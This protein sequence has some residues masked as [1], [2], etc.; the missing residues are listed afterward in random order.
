M[1]DALQAKIKGALRKN[2]SPHHVPDEIIAIQ[3]VPRTLSG[4][5]TEVP[6]KK[7][8]MGVSVEKAVSRDALSN[9]QRWSTSLSSLRRCVRE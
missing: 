1:D 5:K 7:L 3:E 6:V 2:V 8:L 4:K 9:P